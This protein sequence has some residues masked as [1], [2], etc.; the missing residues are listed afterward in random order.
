MT[1]CGHPVSLPTVRY[2]AKCVGEKSSLFRHDKNRISH[3]LCI[4][5]TAMFVY[6]CPDIMLAYY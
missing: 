4:K 3:E 2:N 1:Y 5:P 6:T